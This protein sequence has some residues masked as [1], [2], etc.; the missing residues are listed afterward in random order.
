MASNYGSIGWK[1]MEKVSIAVIDHMKQ[2]EFPIL[3]TQ[4][5]GVIP[6][7][8]QQS[9]GLVGGALLTKQRQ[10]AKSPN[11]P[12]ADT[13]SLHERCIASVKIV[14]KHLGDQV[15][16]GQFS[17]IR[18]QRTAT[19]ILREIDRDSVAFAVRELNGH[20]LDPRWLTEV[21]R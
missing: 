7:A 10:T 21:Y 5:P 6:K 2:V 15:L 8:I 4:P 1:L 12:W 17:S 9:V 18:S 3:G 16:L 20:Q 13:R 19:R 11:H 14:Q